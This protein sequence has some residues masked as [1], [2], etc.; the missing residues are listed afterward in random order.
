MKRVCFGKGENE[1][2]YAVGK[3]YKS[4]IESEIC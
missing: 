1:H 2:L 4:T 3:S